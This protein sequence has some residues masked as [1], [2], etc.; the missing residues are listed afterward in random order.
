M[1]DDPHSSDENN[2][3]RIL[4]PGRLRTKLFS[5]E[6][7][8]AGGNICA[9]PKN[10]FERRKFIELIKAARRGGPTGRY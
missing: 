5:P 3:A 8:E 7:D 10:P 4:P 1:A 2:V 6:G 9:M